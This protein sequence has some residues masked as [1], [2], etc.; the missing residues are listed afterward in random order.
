MPVII[1]HDVL[2]E[3]HVPGSMTGRETQSKEA[4]FYLS[5][6]TKRRKP[7]NVWVCGASGTG[8]TCFAKR[9]LQHLKEEQVHGIYVNCWEDRTLFAVA[10]RLACELRILGSD[11][12]SIG[13]KLAGIRKFLDGK[14]AIIVLDEIDKP[15]PRQRD[16]ILYA[17]S[18]INNLGLV[19]I[20][21]DEHLFQS[22]EERVQS[23]LM[24]ARI[25]F[26]TYSIDQIT[27]ILMERVE[28]ALYES[29]WCPEVLK[30][31]AEG[32]RGNA[33]RAIQILRR[34][35]EYAEARKEPCI[36]KTLKAAIADMCNGNHAHILARLGAHYQLIYNIIVANPGIR[37]R[38]LWNLYNMECGEKKHSPAARRTFTDYLMELEGLRLIRSEWTGVN[39]RSRK[40]WT[41]ETKSI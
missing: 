24:P 33:R 15:P 30:E 27:V 18:T 41:V 37:S 26:P 3:E 10:H 34:A 35:A 21:S 31:I 4:L 14:P 36:C 5:P 17:L 13:A 29:A 23:R 9:L 25:R 19:C 7:I 38:E 39:G 6:A 1:L 32:S 2:S 40:F 20:C 8:K 16:S 12:H 11:M 28:E 22:L